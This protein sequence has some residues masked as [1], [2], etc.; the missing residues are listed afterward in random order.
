MYATCSSFYSPFYFLA[1][2]P[3]RFHNPLQV[4]ATMHPAGSMSIFGFEEVLEF[5]QI[6]DKSEVVTS[7]GG[8]NGGGEED[9]QISAAHV[10][11]DS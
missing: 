10:S 1:N 7:P 11:C 2:N 8:G 5:S 3:E 6:R 9:T 4:W